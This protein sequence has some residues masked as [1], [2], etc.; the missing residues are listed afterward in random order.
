MHPRLGLALRTSIAGGLA[1]FVTQVLPGHEAQRYAY[2]APMGAVVVTSTTVVST[3]REMLRSVAAL[4]L[5]STLGLLALAVVRPNAISVA[6]VIAVSVVLASWKPLGSMR[7]W[8][9]TVAVFTL[10]LG[11]GQPWRYATAYT[12]LS[13]LGA[14]IGAAVVALIPQLVIAPLDDAVHRLWLSI[15]ERLRQLSGALR[16][17]DGA[18]P[19]GSALA[20]TANLGSALRRVE[21]RLAEVQDARRVNRRSRRYDVKTRLNQAR[22]VRKVALRLQDFQR[23][24]ED[25]DPAS[26]SELEGESEESDVL[27]QRLADAIDLIR[28]TLQQGSVE[29]LDDS[30]EPT[31]ARLDE[32]VGRYSAPGPGEHIISTLVFA[33]RQLAL[34]AREA[35]TQSVRQN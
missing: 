18:G 8:V 4:A 29:D 7:A 11:G 27:D 25:S 2:F 5:G 14:A 13:A 21:E 3:A 6:V 34:A 22:A 9:P 31:L 12:G 24:L 28:H 20:D 10:V 1:W 35:V 17:R 30:L 23:R 26:V 16:D 19:F 15:T 32:L 33:L